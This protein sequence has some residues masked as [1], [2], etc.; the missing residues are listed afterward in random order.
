MKNEDEKLEAELWELASNCDGEEKVDALIQL[1]YRSFNRGDHAESLALCETAR[2]LYE[3]LGAQAN[4]STLAHI[5]TG[6]GYSLNR[7]RRHTDA[8]AALDRAVVLYREIGSTEA[9][10]QLRCEGDSWYDAKEYEKAHETYVAAINEAN[11]DVADREVAINYANAG[12]ALIKLK[13]WSEALTNFLA[14]RAIYKT[15]KMPGEIVH[16]DEEIA[17]CY[18]W[19]SNGME[20]LHHAQLAMDFADTA[21]DEFHKMW[22]TARM[23]LAKKVLE[24]YDEALELFADAKSRMVRVE[25]PNWRAV[26]KMERQ[27]A[28]IL[29]IK[30]RV[31]EAQ[32]IERRIA[33]LA[34]VVFDEGEE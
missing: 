23:G 16:C 33:S 22:A 13:R 29:V 27:V 28:S 17:L 11:P 5:Y 14:A 18:Y 30:G 7:L 3:A 34:E 24:E 26:I 20:A 25:N 2:D 21:E 12:S 1:S 8:A 15:L 32:E 4:T 31:S 19:L 10:V 6:I 9:I